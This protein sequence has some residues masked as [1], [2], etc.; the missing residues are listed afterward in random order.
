LP[1][2]SATPSADGDADRDLPL[3]RRAPREHQIGDVGARDEQDQPDGAR[4]HEEREAQ[5][6]HEV[7]AKRNELR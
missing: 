3:P 6:A 4:E 5:V 7:V 1:H 2:E